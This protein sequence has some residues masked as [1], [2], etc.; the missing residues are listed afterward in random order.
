MHPF[1]HLAYYHS[2]HHTYGATD[3][4]THMVISAVVHSLIYG[5]VFRLMRE[6]TVP[7]ALFLAACGIGLAFL[8]AKSRDRRM[9]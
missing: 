3:W 9:L 6:L 5:T 8:W 7:E 1:T 2:Y 4:L